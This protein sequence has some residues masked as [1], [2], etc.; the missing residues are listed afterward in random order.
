MATYRDLGEVFV[1]LVCN[2]DGTVV[3]TFEEYRQVAKN[4]GKPGDWMSAARNRRQMYLVKGPE[5][6]LAFKI[7]KDDFSDKIFAVGTSI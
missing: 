5:G 7:G 2:D 6:Q 1:I 3:L 4:A